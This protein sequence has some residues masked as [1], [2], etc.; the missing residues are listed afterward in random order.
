M[1]LLIALLLSTTVP[2]A[3]TEGQVTALGYC[4]GRLGDMIYFRCDGETRK[5]LNLSGAKFRPGER[6]RL[7]S[8]T[9]TDHILTLTSTNDF[10]RLGQG[11]L[12]EPPEVR[13]AAIPDGTFVNQRVRVRG[14]VMDI[15]RDDIDP[16]WVFLL[17]REG[18]NC[19][20]VGCRDS[21]KQ[22]VVPP[23]DIIGGELELTANCEL[24]NG[25]RKFAG[26]MLIVTDTNDW[27]V[28]SRTADDLFSAPRLENSRDRF[29]PHRHSGLERRTAEGRVLAA[30][31]KN[32]FLLSTAEREP[33]L[34]DL[35]ESQEPPT[36]GDSVLVSGFP[37][38]DLFNFNLAYAKFRHVSNAETNAPPAVPEEPEAVSA[39]ALF[40]NRY[41]KRRFQSHFHGHRLK[42]RG[43][44]RSI[45]DA[46]AHLGL[47]CD[48]LPLE[49]DFSRAQS[50]LP[51]VE[52]DC[53]VEVQGVAVM[54]SDRW[55]TDAPLPR[56]RRIFLVLNSGSDLT[57]LKTPPWW[58]RERLLFA[59]AGLIGSVCLLWLYAAVLHRIINRRCRAL[60]RADIAHAIS[61][62]K[63]DERTRLAVE[64]HDSI[65]QN[66]TG[67]SC[68]VAATC[69]ALPAD[70]KTALERL[71]TA[72]RMLKTCRTELRHQL[73]DLRSDTLDDPDFAR[74]I[75]RTL[76]GLQGSAAI[77]VRTTVPRSHLRDSVAHNLLCIL[78][79]LTANAICHGHAAHVR[80]AG[81]LDGKHLR[82]SVTDDGIG[83][84]PE[85]VPGT[86]E[87]HY[88]LAG[89]RDRI[90][91]L[92][93]GFL[94]ERNP[95]RGMH[96]VITL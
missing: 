7:V 23:P 51:E 95:D 56:I 44:V 87:G 79:E 28:V 4:N 20:Y 63:L 34:V 38:T 58:T 18:N 35:L 94:I 66:L 41:G 77:R 39:R 50:P 67:L 36:V 26:Y 57:I 13:I 43:Y 30:W 64:L 80:I 3:A 83:F 73:A 31:G 92:S 49:V 9:E 17:L 74:A 54:D 1:N 90:N 14:T 21:G 91:R 24:H 60:A 55:R 59:I 61:E 19:I 27:K 69:N 86:A 25:E 84:D 78:R 89:V 93:G 75:E 5:I 47:D 6:L 8:R 70:V 81:T 82:F 68:Q 45:S 10:V 62:F 16:E 12:P 11:P 33:I 15:F 37:E 76:A 42:L 29:L 65:S 88:G 48:G 32:H 71:E 85:H 40:Y 2:L 53:L 72:K 46:D 96:A 22:A 52:P